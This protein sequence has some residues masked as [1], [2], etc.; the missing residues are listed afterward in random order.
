MAEKVF[1]RKGFTRKGLITW[2]RS[3]P[4]KKVVASSPVSENCLIGA[5]CRD[6]LGFKDYG[7]I[8]WKFGQTYT[9]TQT[10]DHDAGESYKENS[11]KILPK[12]AA[13][14]ADKFDSS[15]HSDSMTVEEALKLVG[16]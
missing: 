15:P 3:L 1:R 7:G 16:G 2:L 12:W 9:Y 6:G 5:Y 10:V 8:G 4:P 14:V 13:V 11:P